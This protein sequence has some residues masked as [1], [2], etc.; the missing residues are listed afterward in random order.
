MSTAS[1]SLT[2]FTTVSQPPEPHSKIGEDCSGSSPL[3]ILNI[4]TNVALVDSLPSN[5]HF[6]LSLSMV[7]QHP[8]PWSGPPFQSLMTMHA[9]ALCP[10]RDRDTYSS[11][12]LMTFTS[13]VIMQVLLGLYVK[14]QR[15]VSL[16]GPVPSPGRGL[17]LGVTIR[18]RVSICFTYTSFV[19]SLDKSQSLSRLVGVC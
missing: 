1:C 12:E 15:G 14:T 10:P 13:L 4:L 11:E 7:C 19:I 5:N 3:M 6:V 16:V 17:W 18:V 2:C 9:S 8:A